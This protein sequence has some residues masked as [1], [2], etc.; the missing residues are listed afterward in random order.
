[1][2]FCFHDCS[3]LRALADAVITVVL[4]TI[5]A[6]LNLLYGQG[7]IFLPG[8]QHQSVPPFSDVSISVRF[9]NQPLLLCLEC[10]GPQKLQGQRIAP[11]S[12]NF[13]ELP[14]KAAR[15]EKCPHSPSMSQQACH[16]KQS[17]LPNPNPPAAPVK[18]HLQTPQLRGVI[19]YVC[20][21]G[22]GDLVHLR[23][24]LPDVSCD[25][26]PKLHGGSCGHLHDC[27]GL[28]QRGGAALPGSVTHHAESHWW[29]LKTS[30]A[31]QH[32]PSVLALVWGNSAVCSRAQMLRCMHS[33]H[34]CSVFD[35]LEL[36]QM[37][38]RCRC[39]LTPCP[40]C[41]RVLI[42]CRCVLTLC[43]RVLP[44]YTLPLVRYSMLHCAADV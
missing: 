35:R 1:M 43:R 38:R 22:V 10:C 21:C 7:E 2:L 40:L 16:R 18:L 26:S 33:L 23:V 28:P 6:Y 14:P 13:R 19:C 31:N 11:K 32:C 24:G 17:P 27:G 36:C 8:H 9:H 30:L 42:L 20:S 4:G 41:R 34:R 37:V 29:V 12:C 44:L 15:S 25:G 3:A 5:V 39:V